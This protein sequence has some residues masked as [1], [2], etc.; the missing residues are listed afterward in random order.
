[1]QQAYVNESLVQKKK[2]ISDGN[3]FLFQIYTPSAYIITNVIEDVLVYIVHLI[4]VR[5][6]WIAINEM[7]IL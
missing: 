4:S 1:M 7:F 6:C 2:S 5:R 3:R